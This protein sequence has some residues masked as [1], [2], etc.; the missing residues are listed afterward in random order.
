MKQKLHLF[1]ADIWNRSEVCD[2]VLDEAFLIVKE[3]KWALQMTAS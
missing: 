3:E 2:V 1:Q